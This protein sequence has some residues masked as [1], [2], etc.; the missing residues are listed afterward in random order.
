[1]AYFSSRDV[2]AIS[3]S[4]ALW[5]V[6]NSVFS[7]IFFQITGLPFLCDLIGFSILSVAV[8]WTRKFGII[9]FTGL[10]ATGINFII[11]PGGIHFLGFT[12]ASIV[13]DIF[14]LSFGYKRIFRRRLL[15]VIVIGLASIFSAG[16]AGYLIGLF[17]MPTVILLN[18]GGV[19]GWIGI[20]A[21]GGAIGGVIGVGLIL[22]LAAR[23]V[24]IK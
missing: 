13:F 6:F 10:V 14:I 24:L 17:F 12:V 8:W 18:W 4:A 11:N 7:P 23:S 16:V 5:G 20:H 15:T 2:V 3:I 21:F 1:V 22:S 9:I 19:L